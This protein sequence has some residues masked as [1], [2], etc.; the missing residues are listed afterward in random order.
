M[1]QRT[2]APA[3]ADPLMQHME[4]SKTTKKQDPE[5]AQAS[6]HTPIV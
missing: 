1:T 4:T 5:S 6:A 2:S 3:D